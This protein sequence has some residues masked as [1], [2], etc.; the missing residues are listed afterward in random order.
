MDPIRPQ[1]RLPSEREDHFARYL[2]ATVC[3]VALIAVGVEYY[4]EYRATEQAAAEAAE[5]AQSRQPPR[6][7][8]RCVEEDGR[9]HDQQ[10]P[11]VFDRPRSAPVSELPP[12]S[13]R[14][15]P[16]QSLLDQ[17]DARYAREVQ[18]AARSR[19]QLDQQLAQTRQAEL[20]ARYRGYSCAALCSELG[21][22]RTRMRAGYSPVQGE[23][24]HDLQNR[25]FRQMQVSNCRA[26][27]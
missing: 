22:L 12:V 26:C 5:S 15:N 24:F 27:M 4:I 18:S 3:A 9:S 2:L 20:D 1:T 7:I 14:P 21:E 8:Y 13:R 16:N 6:V 17:A 23:G 25:I 11:C 19:R 10:T